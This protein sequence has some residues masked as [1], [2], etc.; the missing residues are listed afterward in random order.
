MLRYPTLADAPGNVIVVLSVPANVSELEA[1]SVLPSAMV[2]VA[3]VAGAVMAT[4]FTLVAEATPSV[5]VVKEGEVANATTVP[6]P[7]VE[8][9]VPHAEPVELAIPA[10]G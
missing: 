1:V 5:G 6:E 8:Y 3:L 7:V 4:L 10:P 2:S 9:D